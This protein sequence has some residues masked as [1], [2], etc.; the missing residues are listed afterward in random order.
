MENLNK[1][2]QFL[3]QRTGNIYDGKT[4]KSQKMH[5]NKENFESFKS[6]LRKTGLD[7]YI[8]ITSA[9]RSPGQAGSAGSNS[10]HTKRD[11]DG[12]S[13]AYDLVSLVPGKSVKDIISD[14]EEMY[15]Y[16]TSRGARYIDERSKQN[17]HKYNAT[18]ANEH[19]SFGGKGSRE[20]VLFMRDNNKTMNVNYHLDPVTTYLNTPIGQPL[21]YHDTLPQDN[22]QY[23]YYSEI[24][25]PEVT[26]TPESEITEE[27]PKVYMQ[28]PYSQQQEQQEYTENPVQQPNAIDI[29]NYITQQIIAQKQKEYTNNILYNQ[30]YQDLQEFIY[31]KEYLEQ[32][33]AQE[34]DNLRFKQNMASIQALGGSLFDYVTNTFNPNNKIGDFS[35]ISKIPQVRY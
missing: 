20:G 4:E 2:R 34:L 35:G 28:Y 7:R 9:E 26:I 12:N 5:T 31:G 3:Q 21:Q 33:R 27:Q 19:I 18:G 30:T 15:Q 32:Q 14:N 17:Q 6:M 22:D 10:W 8:K 11:R 1:Y 25:L 29:N 13:L 16:V 24:A 23:N